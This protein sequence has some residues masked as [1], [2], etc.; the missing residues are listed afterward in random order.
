MMTGSVPLGTVASG[1]QH[2]ERCEGGILFGATPILAVVPAPLL[3]VRES[4]IQKAL[5]GWVVGFI[6]IA[7]LMVSFMVTKA[8]NHIP[9]IVGTFIGPLGHN[10]VAIHTR[11]QTM[12]KP[13]AT[14]TGSVIFGAVIQIPLTFAVEAYLALART[15]G[16][17]RQ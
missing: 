2:V 1:L 13:K 6:G 15:R 9:G 14:S 16:Q 8:S 7:L 17:S 3:L 11:L 5:P 10:W 12:P 4:F